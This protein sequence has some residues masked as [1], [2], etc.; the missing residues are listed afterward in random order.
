MEAL[1][2]RTSTM[3]TCESCSGASR[4]TEDALARIDHPPGTEK[5]APAGVVRWVSAASRSAAGPGDCGAGTAAGAASTA[6]I[7]K[8]RIP[9]I[10]PGGW[11]EQA[12]FMAAY[13]ICDKSISLPGLYRILTARAASRASVASEIID[14][15]IIISF[16]QRESTGTSV[17]EKAVLVLK[18]RNK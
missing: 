11:Y 7:K 9:F 6:A 1:A 8:R 15:T 4:T 14:C 13:Y 2:A 5:A 17:G 10:K 3:A 18:A 12:I 16:A